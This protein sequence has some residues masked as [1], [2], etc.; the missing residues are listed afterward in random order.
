LQKKKYLI[1]GLGKDDTNK[2]VRVEFKVVINEPAELPNAIELAHKILY[3]EDVKLLSYTA[4]PSE[5]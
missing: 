1:K 3:G 2:L 5:Q 4:T